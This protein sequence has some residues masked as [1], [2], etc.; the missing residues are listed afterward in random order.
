MA[1]WYPKC[2]QFTRMRRLSRLVLLFS[3]YYSQLLGIV[4]FAYNI[5]TGAVRTTLRITLYSIWANISLVVVV[6]LWHNEKINTILLNSKYLHHRIYFIMTIIRGITVVVTLIFNW[7]RRC[8]FMEVI[9]EFQNLRVQHFTDLPIR[10]ELQRQ[11]EK[12]IITKFYLSIFAEI[13]LWALSLETLYSI[14]DWSLVRS[15]FSMFVLTNIL[16][17]MTYH[18]YFGILYVSHHFRIL[19]DELEIVMQTACMVGRRY[20]CQRRPGIYFTQCCELAD[21]LDELAVAHRKLQDLTNRILNMFSLQGICVVFNMY[22]NNIGMFFIVY[23]LFK[24]NAFILSMSIWAAILMIL[25][26]VSYYADIN[27][28]LNVMLDLLQYYQDTA[29]MLKLSTPTQVLDVRFEQSV[30]QFCLQIAQNPL[31]IK[32]LGL[33]LFDKPMAFDIFVSTLLTAVFVMQYDYQYF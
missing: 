28:F 27:K 9:V 25:T 23:A 15:G 29:A 33:F 14:L 16:T 12:C 10:D 11:F 17:V 2:V 22:L 21:R 26:V 7:T 19:N 31:E 32:I 5:K 18:F 30:E 8:K 20:Q 6:V 4:R 24:S 1:N 3:Y 13:S